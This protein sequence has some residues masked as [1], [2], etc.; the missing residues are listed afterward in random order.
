MIHIDAVRRP[1][2][3]YPDRGLSHFPDPVCEAIDEERRRL[4]ERL[5]TM[6]EGD[7]IGSFVPF[8]ASVV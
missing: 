7:R 3:T 2:P 4:I 5:G 8:P 1:A 6:Y